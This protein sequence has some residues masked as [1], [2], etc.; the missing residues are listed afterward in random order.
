[1]T[2]HKTHIIVQGARVHNLKNIS[3]DIPH[4]KFIVIT[5]VSGSGKSSLAFDTLYAEGQR[6]YV[7]SL[8]SYARQFLGRINK[9]EVDII[10]GIPPAIA[11]EQ[12]VNTRNPRSTVG[13]STEIYDFIKLLFARIGQTYS[14]VSGSIVKKQTV[15]DVIDYINSFSKDTKII[16]AAPVDPPTDRDLLE[17]LDIL[18]KKGFSRI[19]IDGNIV[20]IQDFISSKSK[21]DKKQQ[22]I[23]ILIDRISVNKESEENNSRLGD[24]IQTAFYEGQGSCIIK[25]LG[26]FKK[27]KSTKIFS[28]RFEADNIIFEEPNVHLFAFNSSSG[29][30][31]NC[32]GLGVAVGVD[33]DLVVPDKTLSLFDGAI[34]CWK[35]NSMLKWR[36]ELIK[37]SLEAKIDVQ[38]PYLLLSEKEKKF[39]WN[40]EKNF[41]GVNGFFDVMKG[42]SYK[43][44]NRIILARYQGKIVCPHCNGSRLRKEALY[45]KVCGKNISELV[46]MS[47]S[48][49]RLWFSNIN[50]SEHEGTIA[51]RVL[52]EIN[53]RLDYLC[54]VGL[55]YLTLN[56][57]SSSLSGG[58]SQRVN[59]VTIIGSSL[60]GSLYIL[61]EPS[62]GLH[63]KDT[64]L[65][66]QVLKNLRNLGNTVIVVEHDEEMIRSCDEI[67]DIGPGAGRLG[68]E[69]IFQGNFKNLSSAS[70]SL[71]MKYLMGIEKIKLPISRRIHTKKIEV[72]GVRHNNLKNLD[73][74][75]PLNVLTVV[76]GVSGSGKSSLVKNVLY[77]ALKKLK[78]GYASDKTGGFSKIVGDIDA[79][80][81]VE[82][83]DQNPIGKS[84]RSN[85]ATYIKAWDEI[86][87]LFA[88]TKIALAAGMKPSHFSFN[89][90]GGRCDECQGDGTIK[91]E[92]QYLADVILTCESCN[93]QRFKPEVL[94]ITHKGKN[95]YEILEMTVDEAI[96][97]FDNSTTTFEKNI[98]KRLMPLS[99]VGLGYIKLGQTSNTLSGGESQRVKLASFLAL[100]TESP[101]L[102]IFDEPTTGLHFNDI[103]K[104]LQSFDALIQKGHSIIVIEHNME[105]IKMADHIIDLGPEGGDQ[106][107]YLLFSGK[108]EKLI[109]VKN[110]YTGKFLSKYLSSEM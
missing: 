15:T 26:I 80:T 106:G 87:N 71:T 47:V 102:F 13:T 10:K 76:T 61:D 78:G 6:R 58:E 74:A 72:M 30:C 11:I 23:N 27:I 12:K 109:S 82:F 108:P 83:I 43:L 35:S 2:N 14:P 34:A 60:I 9:P 24:S 38:K 48:D 59:L 79:I 19:E 105:I 85:P 92:M 56:R 41:L 69:I 90:E 86:R 70:N 84:S 63:A 65:L 100:E 22:K 104:L 18:N 53:S 75:F 46:M 110:S 28:N 64:K 81:D 20:D 54:N 62:I 93:G 49:L 4:N 31:P 67:I 99:D 7:E 77:N 16:I 96:D 37:N 3:V 73:V 94:E 25:V 97:F 103:K 32:E 44:E 45:V 17:H 98:I 36:F 40:G 101:T 57:L 107:G 29:A 8:S 91:I 33:E 5:G 21:T 95:V 1:M 42:H 88:S 39:I 89:V 68:G 50:L 55:G 52:I 51:K 66:I